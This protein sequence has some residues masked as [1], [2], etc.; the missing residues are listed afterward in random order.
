MFNKPVSQVLRLTLVVVVLLG[1]LPASP[2]LAV[3][4]RSFCEPD[5]QQASG[6]FYR[7]CMPE[8]GRWNGDLVLYAHGYIAP[9]KPVQIPEDQLVLPDGSSIPEIITGLGFA[10]ATTSY[11]TNGLAIREGIEDLLSLVDIFAATHEQ[12]RRVY[13]SGAS[14]GGLI[15]ALAIEQHPDVFDGGLAACGPVGN[16]RRQVNYLGD[17][18]VVFDYFFP[19]VIPGSAVDIPEEVMTNWE[20]VYVPAVRE[21]LASNP[22]ATEQLLRVTSM[23]TD[24][25]DPDSAMDTVLNVLW[26]NVFAGN[27]ARAKLGGQPFGNR[28]RLYHGSDDD[29]QLNQNVQRFSAD[30][31]AL[32]EI[33]AHY[34]T[35]GQ[36]IRPLVTLHTTGDPVVPYWHESLYRAKVQANGAGLLHNNIPV[37]RYGHCNFKTSEILVAFAL[38]VFKASGQELTGAK[39]VLSDAESQAEFLKLAKEHG[40]LH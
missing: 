6:A 37:F 15:T 9:N 32:Q 23:P 13:L 29:S 21:A 24:K 11:S 20:T 28:L 27:D 7:I 2:A 1:S 16:F 36:L 12:P 19:G 18:R 31:I 25:A 4:T 30:V 40:V 33:Q 8:P 35:S 10:F 3:S 22:K 14:E 26:Y 17:V 38:L 5:G 34:Q 39:S